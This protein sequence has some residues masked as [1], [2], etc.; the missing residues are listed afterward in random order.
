MQSINQT[1]AQLSL[2]PVVRQPITPTIAPAQPGW[3]QPGW[4]KRVRL[5]WEDNQTCPKAQHVQL[6]PVKFYTK[7]CKTLLKVSNAQ[8]KSQMKH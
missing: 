3:A 4:V 1:P 8:D 7:K 5:S 2:A 6:A